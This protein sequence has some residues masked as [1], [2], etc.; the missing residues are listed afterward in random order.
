[1]KGEPF[2]SVVRRDGLN[3]EKLFQV[4]LNGTCETRQFYAS[5]FSP[6]QDLRIVCVSLNQLLRNNLRQVVHTLQPMSPS[7]I[8]W[9]QRKLG[10]KQ[11]YRVVHQP[12]SR[13]FAVFANAWLSGWLAEISADLR[14]AV[15]H[16][17]WFST[18]MR[19]TN[20][21]LLY[22]TLLCVSLNLRVFDIST[23]KRSGFVEYE[24]SEFRK[25]QYSEWC[26][27]VAR[28]QG[29]RGHLPPTF[30]ASGASNMVCPPI[31]FNK[32]N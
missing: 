12:V 32:L 30:S 7:S 26:W 19:Y 17:R 18:T 15:A 2:T 10:S 23:G 14:E 25:L 1:M 21:R 16:Q 3:R 31:N 22:F 6:C 8:I 20:P 28:E 24:F 29:A 13:G 9:Y 27:P 5:I 11:A 4:R